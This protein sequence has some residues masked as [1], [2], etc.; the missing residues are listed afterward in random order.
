MKLYGVQSYTSSAELVLCT[1]T[2][3]APGQ[4]TPALGRTGAAILITKALW[5]S[6]A[7]QFQL[8]SG[9]PHSNSDSELPALSAAFFE[10]MSH[11]GCG[12]RHLGKPSGCR[13]TMPGRLLGAWTD[14][15]RTSVA[16]EL[17]YPRLFLRFVYIFYTPSTPSPTAPPCFGPSSKSVAMHA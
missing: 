4:C 17:S 6:L 10:L 1:L 8:P 13:I 12:P 5:G 9:G 7:Q 2:V 15:Y 16:R 14:T 11:A 3:H